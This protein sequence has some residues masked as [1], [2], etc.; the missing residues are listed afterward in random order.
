[1]EIRFYSRMKRDVQLM[2]KRGRDLSGL[3]DV[4]NKLASGEMLPEINIDF[5]LTGEWKDF[6]ACHIEPDC[7]LIYHI[8]NEVLILG[9]IVYTPS[10][11]TV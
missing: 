2:K 10:S 3:E 9:F 1:M 6:R 7:C 8:E 11:N 5:P 4:L